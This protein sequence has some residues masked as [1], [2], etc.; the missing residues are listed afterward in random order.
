M[1]V[2]HDI[3]SALEYTVRELVAA[4]HT[5]II[6]IR[7]P[8][9]VKR[10]WACTVQL[11]AESMIFDSDERGLTL[12]LVFDLTSRSAKSRF[13]KFAAIPFCKQFNTYEFDGMPCFAMRFG[14]DVD[15]ALT[16]IQF[17][18]TK[19][20]GY[21]ESTVFECGVSDEGPD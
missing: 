18:L 2:F 14:T 19:L 13:R 17:V 7:G 8:R 1:Q 6:N 10:R 5:F 3:R 12:D 4:R 11:V 21:P 9:E 20:W 15:M 16:V